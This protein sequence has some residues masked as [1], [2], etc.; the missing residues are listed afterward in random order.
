MSDTYEIDVEVELTTREEIISVPIEI[1]YSWQNDGIGAYEFWGQKCYDKGSSYAEVENINWNEEGF[2]KQEIKE[3]N[4][5]IDRQIDN[6]ILDIEEGYAP[7]N[8]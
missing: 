6:I 7:E 3:I 1:E 8:C 5:E 2:T 4:A